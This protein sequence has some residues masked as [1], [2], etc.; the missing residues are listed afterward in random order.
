M[1]AAGWFRRS[2]PIILFTLL[3]YVIFGPW[4]TR[5]IRIRQYPLVARPL[6]MEVLAANQA[7]DLQEAMLA[8][9]EGLRSLTSAERVE[10][11][12]RLLLHQRFDASSTLCYM[13]IALQERP[14]FIGRASAFLASPEFQDLSA[15]RQEDVSRLISWIETVEYD[16]W[17]GQK[18]P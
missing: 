9:P 13:H 11:Y 4:V 5:Q 14:M 2:W 3:L 8:L 16:D 15:H 12:L 10:I 18:L 6:V 17:S 7:I 1:R